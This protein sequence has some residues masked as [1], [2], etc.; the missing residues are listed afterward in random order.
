MTN[1]VFMVVMGVVGVVFF[2]KH[3]NHGYVSSSQGVID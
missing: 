2:V 1:L 3:M